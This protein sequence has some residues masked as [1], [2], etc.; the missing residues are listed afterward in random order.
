[1]VESSNVCSPIWQG[2][3]QKCWKHQSKLDTRAGA[4]LLF[5][6][7]KR[8]SLLGNSGSIIREDG[9]PLTSKAYGCVA[10]GLAGP[11]QN[12]VPDMKEIKGRD[13]SLSFGLTRKAQ[14]ALSSR[15]T[16]SRFGRYFRSWLI[17]LVGHPP[18][19]PSRILSMWRLFHL[20]LPFRSSHLF[21]EWSGE[22]CSLWSLASYSNSYSTSMFV[23]FFSNQSP[24][25]QFGRMY[26]LSPSQAWTVEF[27]S[28]EC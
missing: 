11:T 5:H 20:D 18:S 19:N 15:G 13:A 23:H 17:N 7:S 10:E 6:S 12:L 14:W 24:V 2:D 4:Q 27:V 26:V 22:S 1:M 25:N 28:L 3:L 21:V 9:E 16:S 8:I